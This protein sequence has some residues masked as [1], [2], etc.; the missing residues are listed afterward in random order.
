MAYLNANIPLQKVL[1]RKE[2][3]YD[4]NQGFGEYEEG[5]LFAACAIQGRA[6]MFHV[7]IDNG[8]VYFRLPISAFCRKPCEHMSLEV[9]E[10]WDCLSNDINVIEYRL[11]R[12]MATE[13]FLKDKKS[14][15]GLYLFTIDFAASDPNVLDCSLVETPGEHKCAHFIE[16]DSGQFCLVPNNRVRFKDASLA[17]ESKPID[18]KIQTRKYFSE[19]GNKWI[20][21]NEYHYAMERKED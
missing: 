11:L 12:N 8:A 2:Y 15:Q 6:L 14:Y 10:T 19:Y 1:V 5:W 16:L 18:Y 4:F 9:L 20:A 7:L 17:T 13:P 21:T 3:L